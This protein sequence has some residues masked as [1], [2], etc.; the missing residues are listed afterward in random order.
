MN[1]SEKYFQNFWLSFSFFATGLKNFKTLFHKKNFGKFLKFLKFP[2]I[3]FYENFQLHGILLLI[4]FTINGK[5]LEW[6]KIGESGSQTFWQ[7]K[8]WRIYCKVNKTSRGL[9]VSWRRKVWQILPIRQIHQTLAT[10][11]FCCLQ[12]TILSQVHC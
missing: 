10:P 6:L 7:I 3:K 12:Y 1:I 5:S 9:I 2:K 11:N 8:V 4:G